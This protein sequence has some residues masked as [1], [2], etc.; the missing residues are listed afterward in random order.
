VDRLEHQCPTGDAATARLVGHD[1]PGTGA[2][3]PEQPSEE[4]LGRL[5]FPARLQV[6]VDDVADLVDGSP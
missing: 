1:L 4:S 6:D 5:G 2:V 3:R